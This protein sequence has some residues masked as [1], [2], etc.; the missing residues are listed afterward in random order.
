MQNIKSACFSLNKSGFI[1]G[2]AVA[3]ITPIVATL[4]AALQVA[5]FNFMSSDWKQSACSA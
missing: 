5:G 3:F 2:A 1:E 4:G